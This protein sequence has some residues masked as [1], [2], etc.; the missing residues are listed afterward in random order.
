MRAILKRFD[1]TYKLE[2]GRRGGG[3]V[4]IEPPFRIEFRVVKRNHRTPNEAVIRIYNLSDS[5]IRKMSHMDA[6]AIF[7]AGYIEATGA[8][9]IMSGNVTE[10]SVRYE[11]VDKVCEITIKSGYVPLRDS[12]TAM[13]IVGGGSTHTALR[14]VAE[15]MGL[16]LYIEDGTRNKVYKESASF[17]GSSHDALS[18]LTRAANL[19]WSIQNNTIRVVNKGE[20]FKNKAYLLNSATGLIGTPELNIKASREKRVI[21]NQKDTKITATQQGENKYIIKS[22][23]LPDLVPSN[24]ISVESKTANGVY[25]IESIEHEGQYPEGEWITTLEVKP[26]EFA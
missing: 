12:T 8:V 22:L 1:K 10:L 21:R 25:K 6:V 18:K 17:W 19:E 26:P 20:S 14:Q 4:L 16:G 5:T 13:T 11:G 7:S 23:L 9:M 24:R 2:V 15:D 3:G